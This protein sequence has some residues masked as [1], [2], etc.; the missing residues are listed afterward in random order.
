MSG[1]EIGT[2]NSLG[3]TARPDGD[4]LKLLLNLLALGHE[5]HVVA[6]GVMNEAAVVRVQGLRLNRASVDPH[7][8]SQLMNSLKE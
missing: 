2:S 6:V 8:F 4:A 3:G 7:C 5:L 1:P